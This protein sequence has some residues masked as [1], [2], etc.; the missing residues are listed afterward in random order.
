MHERIDCHCRAEEGLVKTT[1][2]EALQL[3][4]VLRPLAIGQDLCS[5]PVL[6][7]DRLLVL[8]WRACDLGGLVSKQ[9]PSVSEAISACASLSTATYP[10]SSL[11]GSAP[12]I[13]PPTPFS[14]CPHYSSFPSTVCNQLSVTD[15]S[16]LLDIQALLLLLLFSNM[17]NV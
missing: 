6:C 12:L 5:V 14:S 1:S 10:H 4:T 17:E 16:S 15:G 2:S 7:Y 13:L 8:H 3:P 9:L 11:K